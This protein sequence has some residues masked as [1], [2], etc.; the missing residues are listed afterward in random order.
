MAEVRRRL[1]EDHPFAMLAE[2]SS[3]YAAVDP[4]NRSPFEREPRPGPTREELIAESGRAS[5]RRLGSD[6]PIR[7]KDLKES[8]S[9]CAMISS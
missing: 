6:D 1:R 9:P 2:A 5:T 4:R 7:P 3:I 8:T